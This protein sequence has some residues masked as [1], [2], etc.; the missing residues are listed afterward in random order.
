MPKR[1]KPDATQSFEHI[2]DPIV[3]VLALSADGVLACAVGS[4]IRLLD[5]K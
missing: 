4:S 5:C 1:P 2:P 3:R